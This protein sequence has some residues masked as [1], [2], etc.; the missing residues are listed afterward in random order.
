MELKLQGR[1]VLVTGGSQGIGYAIA[2][3]F[4]KK[5]APL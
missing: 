5:A 3:G 2:E 4:W 1:R